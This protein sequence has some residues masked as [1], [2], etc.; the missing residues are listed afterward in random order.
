MA[1]AKSCAQAFAKEKFKKMDKPVLSKQAFKD[2]DMDEIDY[3]NG[4]LRVFERV[5]YRGNDDDIREI[6]RFYGDERIRKEIVN[7]KCFGPKEVNFCCFIFDLKLEDFIYYKAGAFR[8][9]PEFKDCPDDFV[10]EPFA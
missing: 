9:Y 7:S 8:A 2:V 3:E 4:V 6:R 10:Y 1:T 5:M